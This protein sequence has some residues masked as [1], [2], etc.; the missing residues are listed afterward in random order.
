MRS[1]AETAEES[2]YQ[3]RAEVSR[4]REK[5]S[6]LQ[7]E[8]DTARA[9]TSRVMNQLSAFDLQAATFAEEKQRLADQVRR[10]SGYAGRITVVA[11]HQADGEVRRGLNF[12]V[13]EQAKGMAAAER[14]AERAEEDLA[15]LRK[16]L[17]TGTESTH[18]VVEENVAL[19]SQ[20]RQTPVVSE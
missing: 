6:A 1:R 12:Q 19:G 4:E 3:M 16:R 14:R 10:S 20:V 13:K 17:R 9:E 5:K 11:I 18:Q 15:T 8:L 2:A 7:Q